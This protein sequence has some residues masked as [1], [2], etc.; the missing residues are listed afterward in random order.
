M[1]QSLRDGI[2]CCCIS[3]ANCKLVHKKGKFLFQ[4]CRI[5]VRYTVSLPNSLI[6]IFMRHICTQFAC[7]VEHGLGMICTLFYD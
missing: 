5:E 6:N 3:E 2:A 7:I 4:L 1:P